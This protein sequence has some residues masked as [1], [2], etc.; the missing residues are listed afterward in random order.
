MSRFWKLLFTPTVAAEQDRHGS[1]P[2]YA[3]LLAERGA[4]RDPGLDPDV[5]GFIAARD[6]FYMATISASGWPH[7]QHRGGPV[8]FVRQVG[9]TAIGWADFSGNR[10]Y[11]SI[12]NSR[13]EARVALFFMDYPNRRRLKLL[14]RL[15]AVEAGADPALDALLYPEDYRARVEHSIV[16]EVEAH[17]WNCPQHITP[18]FTVAEMEAQVASVSR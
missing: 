13:D 9:P 5:V 2:T 15:C 17:D 16:I 8:G 11:I 14:G 3:R 6:S 1:G 18:R 4:E 10:Q 7:L 12:G